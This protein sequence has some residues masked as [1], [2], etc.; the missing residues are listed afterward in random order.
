MDPCGGDAHR[1]KCQSVSG[2]NYND[3][4]LTQGATYYYAVSAVNA[5]G[6]SANSF[7]VSATP[8]LP[9]KLAAT[10]IGSAGSYGGTG[11]TI[12][13]AFDNNLT[14]YYDAA[15]ASGDWAGLDLGTNQRIT[16]I[17]YCPRATWANRMVGGVFQGA[18]VA[19]FSSGVATL[20]TVSATPPHG[21][22]TTQVITDPGSYRYLSRRFS[23]LLH[24]DDP[25]Q[26]ELMLRL[27]EPTLPYQTLGERERRRL[28]VLAYQ[29]DGQHHQTGTG[30]QFLSRLARTPELRSELGE[31]AGVLQA[32]GNL[33]FRPIPGLEGVPLCLHASYGIREVLTAVGWLTSPELPA[34]Q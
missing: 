5:V 16:Q 17:T 7:E 26:S 12:A 18:N 21:V 9:A 31:L 28:Q 3:S 1:T 8:Y 4:G 23:D 27:S 19:D 33:R 22:L 24:I 20:F 29:V 13:K 14:T 2:T 30:E 25:E 32:R 6:E 15:N 10:V 34:S 11:N